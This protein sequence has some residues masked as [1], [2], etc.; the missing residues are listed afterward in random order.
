M[1]DVKRW[2]LSFVAVLLAGGIGLAARPA[3]SPEEG[4]LK[5]TVDY[6]GQGQVDKTHQVIV[7]AFDTPDINENSQPI[8]TDVVTENG[9]SVSFTG[10]P[11]TVYLAAAYNEKG[12]YDGTGGP[13]PSGTP[14]TVYGGIGTASGVATGDD[15]AAVTVDFDDSTRMP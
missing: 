2:Q 13:P 6:K 9:G 12:D 8:A 10:L 3:A 15:S 11:K 7:W 14:V 5:V 4:H 1:R